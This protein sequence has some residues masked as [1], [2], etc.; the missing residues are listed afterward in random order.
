MFSIALCKSRPQPSAMVFDTTAAPN[1][2]MN[3]I[4]QAG[5][6]GRIQVKAGKFLSDDLNSGYDSAI[7]FNISQRL[8]PVQ[9]TDLLGKVSK[10]LNVRGMAVILEQY[11]IDLGRPFSRAGNNSLGLSFYH[12]PGGQ[13]NS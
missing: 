4:S 1:T 9:I 8:T 6:S 13:V 11:G 3:N 10:A 5:L 7:L 2:R 12:L